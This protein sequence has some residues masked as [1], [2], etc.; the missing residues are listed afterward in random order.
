MTQLDAAELQALR[1]ARDWQRLW[2]AALPLV[3]LT[4]T[5]LISSGRITTDQA[6]DDLLQEGN[7]AAGRAIRSW[8]PDKGAFSTWVMRAAHGAMLDHLRRASSGMVGGR[9]ARGGTSTLIE[10]AIED[11]GTFEEAPEALQRMQESM[12]LRVS[13]A[14]LKSVQDR[15]LIKRYY[16]LGC[17]A[18]QLKD[19][20][21]KWG[22]PLRTIERM[23]TGALKKLAGRLVK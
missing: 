17:E 19:I 15:E 21:S 2:V 4:I 16:G 23:L 22:F 10:E 1:K 7:L 11:D 6:T 13:I 3:K 9:A 14:S 20:A 5:R 8:D 12:Q 18:E